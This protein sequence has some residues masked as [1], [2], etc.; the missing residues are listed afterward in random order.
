MN[1]LSRRLDEFMV[2]PNG[3]A[4]LDEA[5]PRRVSRIGYRGH[6]AAA[7]MAW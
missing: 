3:L 5:Q 7:T 6:C 1:C 2:S 4:S